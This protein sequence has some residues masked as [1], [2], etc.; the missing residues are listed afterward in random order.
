MSLLP[1]DLLDVHAYEHE[2]IRAFVLGQ[3]IPEPKD[4]L[5]SSVD[6]ERAIQEA[7]ITEAKRICALWQKAVVGRA[8]ASQTVEAIGLLK[9]AQL[10]DA[11]LPREWWRAT[12][13]F[14]H[15]RAT[16]LQALL[17]TARRGF[18]ED[19]NG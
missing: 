8:L 11:D 14:W 17:D 5:L 13:M 9:A 10:D 1:D 7:S 3:P 18:A 6:F 2:L 16:E 4:V 15:K 19:D 12:A